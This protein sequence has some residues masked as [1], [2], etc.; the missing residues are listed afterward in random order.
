MKE[1]SKIQK[2]S[3]K[4]LPPNAGKGRKAG[5]PNKATKS[6]RETVT[7][8]LEE[9]S[10]NV[11]V[12]LQQVAQQD[13]AKALDLLAKLAEYAAPKLSRVEQSGEVAITNGYHFAIERAHI[14]EDQQDQARPH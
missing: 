14:A 4:K 6:F 3:A 7:K 5:V 9:N 12:W 13:P 11:S 8:V 1:D 10:A 2:P